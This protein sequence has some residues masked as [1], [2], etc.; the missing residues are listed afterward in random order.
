M[1][2]LSIAA[3]VLVVLLACSTAEAGWG[4][5]VPA[6][7]VVYNYW[8]VGPVYTY[9]APVAVPAPAVVTPAPA[10]VP[11][12]VVTYPWV[13]VRGRFGRRAVLVAP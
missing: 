12:P 9:P 6:G 11:A 1:R 13:Y 2:H 3:A 10:V 8:P 4:Y 5:V 7:T